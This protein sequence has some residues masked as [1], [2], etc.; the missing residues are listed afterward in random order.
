M[1]FYFEKFLEATSFLGV[2]IGYIV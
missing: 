2:K 1:L